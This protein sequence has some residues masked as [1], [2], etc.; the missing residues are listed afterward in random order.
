MKTLTLRIL[1]WLLVR[2]FYR[3]RPLAAENMPLKGGALLVSNHISFVDML[4][5]LASTP[6]FVRFVLPADICEVWWLKPLL[7][8]LRVIPLPAAAQSREFVRAL[9]QAREAVQQGEVVG[10]FPE[11]NISRIGVLLP[12]RKDIERIMKDM[13]A[14][15]IPV[16]LDGL[17][18]SVFSYEKKRFFWKLPR[19]FAHPVTISFGKELPSST[20]AFEVR[21]VIQALNTEAWPHR[22]SGLRLLHRAFVGRARR[23]PFRFAMADSRVPSSEFRWCFD[24]SRFPG[25]PFALALGG[26]GDGGHPAAALGGR[27]ARELGG[28]AIRKGAREPQLHALG[29]T[30]DLVCP[31]MQPPNGGHFTSL[32][33]SCKDEDPLPER[34]SLKKSRPIRL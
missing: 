11:H 14:P 26:T 22:R 21:S 4:L 19:Q 5:I 18:G 7:R 24:Q 6:R 13:A 30:A 10:I 27:G 15:V 32:S 31:A 8:Y 2:P 20:T 23:Y 3:I 34:F 12:F 1:L 25:S 16:C 33:R 29:G 9:D 17:W 28:P